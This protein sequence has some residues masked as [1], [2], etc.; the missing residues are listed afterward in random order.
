ME[1][2]CVTLKMTGALF[3]LAAGGCR[4]SMWE[5][6]LMCN[7]LKHDLLS[8][9]VLSHIESEYLKWFK[10]SS[11]SFRPD[12][13]DSEL[14]NISWRWTEMLLLTNILILKYGIS[15]F[16]LYR[17]YKIPILSTLPWTVL[18]ESCRSSRCSLDGSFSTSTRLL[19]WLSDSSLQNHTLYLYTR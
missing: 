14:T 16:S 18:L 4:W 2:F 15:I 1:H 5:W 13:P 8:E 12:W 7:T 19:F 10:Y 17:I 11:T 6:S 3:H 9:P